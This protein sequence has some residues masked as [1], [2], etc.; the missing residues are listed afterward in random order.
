ML[1]YA[2]LQSFFS[3]HAYVLELVLS[4]WLFCH[5]F[6]KRRLF[7]LRSILVVLML[8]ANSILWVDFA[9]FPQDALWG[10]V[11]NNTLK[12]LAYFT[13]GYGGIKFCMES[14]PYGPLFCMICALATQHLAFRVYS[15]FLSVFR[16]S[17]TA[18]PS[19]F[20]ITGVTALV[21]GAV[22]FLLVRQMG[23][24][25]ERCYENKLNILVGGI[26]IL[27]TLVLQFMLEPL[28]PMEASAL[29]YV[30]ISAYDG[31]CCIF[32]L[33]LEQGL[34][35]NNILTRDKQFLEHLVHMQEEQYRT[36]K[37]NVE[38]INIKCH[39]IKH[40]I[41]N[42]T[43]LGDPAARQEL[44][45][46]ISIYD[47]ALQTGNEILDVCLMEKK[48]LCERSGIKFNCIANGECLSFMQPSDIFS[49]FGNAIDNAMEAVCKLADEE[50]RIISLDVREQL[51]MVVIHLENS[52]EGELIMHDGLPKTTKADD[53]FHGFGVK[54]I[55]MVAEK[56][57][58]IVAVLPQ[59]GIFNLNITIPI[60]EKED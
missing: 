9:P 59:D 4:I 30:L 19:V 31:I 49:M 40:Q 25:Q 53:M 34:L 29:A 35:R 45:Q 32:V 52:F 56:Y 24:N 23:Q 46:I 44:E 20:I 7:V 47:A 3:H 1:N 5:F 39:D 2:A 43:R 8:L 6:K 17:F 36:A 28:V 58:G 33:M 57:M 16:L 18:L 26:L 12:Y 51:G 21:Y 54:S 10:T 41:T 15:S 14:P 38:I 50:K 42:M 22:Y 13:I 11:I 48:L 27:F 37:A 60:P 55:R